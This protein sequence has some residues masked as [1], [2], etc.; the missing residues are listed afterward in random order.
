MKN[1]KNIALL[2]VVGIF[3]LNC[4]DVLEDGV[5]DYQE[6]IGEAYGIY[7][8]YNTGSNSTYNLLDPSNSIV[9][10]I[11]D[12]ALS[13]GAVP[14][15]G[16]I[17]AAINDGGF[18]K[19]TDV[20]SFPAN[21]NISLT[22]V[23]NALG[24]TTSSLT[25]G[26]IVKFKTFFID[27]KGDLTTSTSNFDAAIVCPPLAGTYIIEMQDSYGDG[28]QGGGINA[29][30]D[31]IVTFINIPNGGG[32]TGSATFVVPVGATA[33]VWEYVNDTY[34]EEVSFQIYD[35]NGQLIN[36]SS[37][38]TPGVLSVPSTCP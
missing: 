38:P 19:V 4:N 7:P 15:S 9:D 31:G 34:N 35:P 21:I 28:W 14:S 22:E 37:N 20:S 33:L 8:V 10:F 3:F 18:S 24:I 11:L 27:S 12:V 6:F 26:D 17:H 30:L 32:S 29:I 1:I 16:E 13:G 2:L 25:G 36:S 23:V 5:R